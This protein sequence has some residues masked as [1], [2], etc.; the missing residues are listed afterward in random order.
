[1]SGPSGESMSTIFGMDPMPLSATILVVTFVGGAA[2]AIR[3]I[4]AA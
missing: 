2:V 4:V 3:L 1:M